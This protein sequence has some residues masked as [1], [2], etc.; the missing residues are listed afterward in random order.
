V[1]NYGDGFLAIAFGL[2]LI[3]WRRKGAR[4]VETILGSVRESGNA[5]CASASFLIWLLA[6][7]W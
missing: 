4:E 1:T 2:A 5:R 7:E 3:L 6:L